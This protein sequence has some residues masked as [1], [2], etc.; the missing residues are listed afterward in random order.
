[1]TFPSISWLQGN[2][3][4]VQQYSYISLFIII[5]FYKKDK[6]APPSSARQMLANV[7][8]MPWDPLRSSCV[9]ESFH[10][11]AHSFYPQV[12][13]GHKWAFLAEK[14]TL[15]TLHLKSRPST[16]ITEPESQNGS[17]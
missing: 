7:F 16:A 8:L 15:V 14:K 10:D 4:A 9:H 12:N 5:A 3:C 13:F 2:L 6:P 17:G 1:M 11:D